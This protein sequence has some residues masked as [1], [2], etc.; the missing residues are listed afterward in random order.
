MFRTKNLKPPSN[1]IKIGKINLIINLTKNLSQIIM[2]FKII[3]EIT[4]IR[5]KVIGM[6]KEKRIEIIVL[7]VIEMIDHLV[8]IDLH[9]VMIDKEETIVKIKIGSQTMIGMLRQ[10]MI[11]GVQKRVL[12]K[13]M[14]GKIIH[15][16][17]ANQF[18]NLHH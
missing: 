2:I 3:E 8:K 17:Q 15:H 1:G 16:G 11:N 14:N 10:P 13:R 5:G 12:N 4:I 7:E 9:V 18:R 6:I